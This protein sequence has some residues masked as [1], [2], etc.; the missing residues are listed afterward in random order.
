MRC[1][2][3]LLKISF[4]DPATKEDARRKIQAAIGKYDELPTLV[5][6]LKLRKF[7]HI[8]R[9]FGL[10]KTIVQGTVK[11]KRRKVR[12]KQRWGD[13]DGRLAVC[14]GFNDPLLQYFSLYRAV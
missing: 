6:K 11:V 3:R 8:S 2:L 7:G 12:Q 4:K 1:Y 10:A 14:L 5:K 13:R 9:S